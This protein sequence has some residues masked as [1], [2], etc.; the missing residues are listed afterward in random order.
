MGSFINPIKVWEFLNDY[1][2][3]VG[4]TAGT[5]NGSTTSFSLNNDNI[6]SGSTT[7][8]TDSGQ[9]TSGVTWDYDNGD[10]TFSSAPD[11]GSS[12]TSDYKHA[13]IPNSVITDFIDQIESK[14]QEIAKRTLTYQTNSTQYLD[15]EE[16]QRTFFTRNF[17]V[18]TISVARN[19]NDE[20]DTP[21]WESL[22]SGLG[23]HYIMTDED[24]KIGRIRFIDKW[25]DKGKNRL[26]VIYSYGYSSGDV[27]NVVKELATLE[28][29]RK[30]LDSTVY[31][32][33]TGGKEG[34]SPARIEQ[35]DNRITELSKVIK[36]D[37]FSL[38]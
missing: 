33:Y 29:A 7:I 28:T 14:I 27:P 25:P 13:S 11:S 31:K 17:P 18:N 35:I 1:S 24:K 32:A 38:L 23:N 37:E 34:F 19:K 9:V 26:R 36:R 8:Y 16:K 4:E 5:G 20:T 21:D 3:I 12:I 30:V 15:V 10:F 22:T 6:V 2:K